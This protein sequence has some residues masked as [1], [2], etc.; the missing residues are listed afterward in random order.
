LRAFIPVLLTVVLDSY[1]NVFPTHIQIGD[2]VTEFVADR[3]LGQ[4]SR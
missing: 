4:R 2:G 1:F 3:Y